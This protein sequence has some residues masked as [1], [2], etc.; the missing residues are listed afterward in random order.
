MNVSFTLGALAKTKWYEYLVRFAFGGAITVTARF[1]AEHFGP[2]FGGLFL[3]FPAIF[4][5]SATLVAKHETHKKQN[6]GIETNSRACQA[7][8]VDAAGAPLGSVGLAAFA[9]TVWKFLPYYN[10]AF[11]F[12]AAKRF[13]SRWPSSL[14]A[15][16]E[17]TVAVS[18][19]S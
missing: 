12:L 13:G 6:A 2:V 1:L 4:P 17:N 5:A 18:H 3:A 7:V 9:L 19:F 8:A 11:V 10:S 15:F 16:G 14:G